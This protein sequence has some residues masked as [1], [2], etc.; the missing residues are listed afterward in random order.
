MDQVGGQHRPTR[1]IGMTKTTVPEYASAKWLAAY[2]DMEPRTI[3]N[4]SRRGH[5]RAYK[6]SPKLVR[7]KVSEVLSALRH[8]DEDIR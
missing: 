8:G 1:E 2:L 5:Y 7:Y 4:L 6:I 3:S